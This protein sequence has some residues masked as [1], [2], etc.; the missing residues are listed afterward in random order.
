L[1]PFDTNWNVGSGATPLSTQ[2]LFFGDAISIP[3]ATTNVRT[4]SKP[5][6]LLNFSIFFGQQNTGRRTVRFGIHPKLVTRAGVIGAQVSSTSLQACGVVFPFAIPTSI[7][8]S[9][10]TICSGLYLL[11]DMTSFPSRKRFSL[12]S[13]GTKIPGQVSGSPI[14]AGSA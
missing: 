10:V 7:C 13:A 4:A 8:R 6:F 9:K 5:P 2:D 12:T 14:C 11:M 3:T 1:T